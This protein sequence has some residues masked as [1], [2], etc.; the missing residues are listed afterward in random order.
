MIQCAKERKRRKN[1]KL[2]PVLTD[3]G[4]LGKS[5]D[6][7]ADYNAK[8]V[9]MSSDVAYAQV[10]NEGGG[11]KNMP[12]RQFMGP[13]KALEKKII[14]KIDREIDKIFKR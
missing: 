8:A 12:Q 2:P 5:I 6:W 1:G 13:S 14:E 4:N 7:N 3:S 11:P 9:V 10:H